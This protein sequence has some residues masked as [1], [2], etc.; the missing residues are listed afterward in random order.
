MNDATPAGGLIGYARAHYLRT[1]AAGADRLAFVERVEDDTSIEPELIEAAIERA[2]GGELGLGFGYAAHVGER[3][4]ERR[5]ICD[6]Y[7][8]DRGSSFEVR[9]RSGVVQ[10]EALNKRAA[11]V[12]RAP[13]CQV[14]RKPGRARYSGLADRW[15]M[16][17]SF[18]GL[19]GDPRRLGHI[20][21]RYELEPSQVQALINK[22]EMEIVKELIELQLP[23]ADDEMV[24]AWLVGGDHSKVGAGVEFR[25]AA[26]L[27]ERVVDAAARR[28]RAEEEAERRKFGELTDEERAEQAERKRAS[29]E[30][31]AAPKQ[32]FH[33]RLGLTRGQVMAVAADYASLG[34]HGRAEKEQLAARHGLRLDQLYAVANRAGVTGSSFTHEQRVEGAMAWLACGPRRQWDELLEASG[35][36]R[37]RSRSMFTNLREKNL[38]NGFVH[39]DV[40][41]PHGELSINAVSRCGSPCLAD[42]ATLHTLVGHTVDVHF[43]DGIVT[44]TITDAAP[45]GDEGSLP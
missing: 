40:R 8:V 29:D 38:S 44:G 43:A 31:D 45:H 23:A 7:D 37:E 2:I 28:G 4:D 6:S 9:M 26:L 21:A 39:L 25:R 33:E 10:I 24:R 11:K 22:A 42:P 19:G 20:A 32:P 12:H 14:G 35:I 30:S 1:L 16:L 13:E 34:R 3:G 15:P 36:T 17:R 27:A 41:D 18:V 5:V